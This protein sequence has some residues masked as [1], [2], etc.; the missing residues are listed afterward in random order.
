M[1]GGGWWLW[2]TSH[3]SDAPSQ[4]IVEDFV[5]DAGV[6][7]TEIDLSGVEALLYSHLAEKWRL[8]IALPE[9]RRL[10]LDRQ[11]AE[12]EERLANEP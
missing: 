6:R 12:L 5:A 11:A 9:L 2:K 1:A 3:P 8:A 4:E 7:S 10:G